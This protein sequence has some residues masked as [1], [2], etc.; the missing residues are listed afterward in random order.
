MPPEAPVRSAR[1]PFRSSATRA[2]YSLQGS[3][4]FGD[5]KKLPDWCLRM[6][7]IALSVGQGADSLAGMPAPPGRDIEG[8]ARLAGRLRR[9]WWLCLAVL[10]A[11]GVVAAV[12]LGATTLSADPSPLT[13]QQDVSD[14]GLTHTT[15][16]TNNGPDPV[17]VQTVSISNDLGCDFTLAGGETTPCAPSA[18]IAGDGGIC[19]VAVSF[20]PSTTGPKS[21]FVDLTTDGTDADISVPLSGSATERGLSR[22][23]DL[24]FGDQDVDDD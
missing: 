16:I 19:E 20:D 15:T 8:D 18:T 24:A 23:T 9:W 14:G 4:V 3:W 6:P 22:D 7:R 5:L 2:S 12:A 10:V 1:A 13:F 21:A 17:T 11:G